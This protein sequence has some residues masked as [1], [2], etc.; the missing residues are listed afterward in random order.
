MQKPNILTEE[1]ILEKLGELD[2]WSYKDNK[3]SK[4]FQFSD[5]MD[6]LDFINKL[7]PYCESI[8]HHPDAHIFY[9]K[10]LFELQRFDVGGKVTDKDF[11]VAHEIEKL[12][13][14]R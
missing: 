12:Y 8:D 9:N 7:A 13:A 3:I 2:G 4:Q 6:S 14:E 10:V 11:M 5:F 1:E